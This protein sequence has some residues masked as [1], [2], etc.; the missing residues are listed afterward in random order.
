[1]PHSGPALLVVRPIKYQPSNIVG[2]FSDLETVLCMSQHLGVSSVLLTVKVAQPLQN[3]KNR[4]KYVFPEFCLI[5]IINPRTTFC[6]N[7]GVR[8]LAEVL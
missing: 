2:H 4:Q 1:M 5:L 3:G 8:I 7:L 6:E